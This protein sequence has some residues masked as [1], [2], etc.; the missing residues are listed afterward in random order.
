MRRAV[1][2]GGPVVLCEHGAGQSYQ[3]NHSSY[4]GGRGREQV[5]LFLC[6]NE[7]AAERNR[8]AYPGVPA[9]A[10]GCPKLD[11]YHLSP[12][13]PRGA[14]PVLALSFHWDC[15]VAPESRWA[16]PPYRNVLPGL[17]SAYHVLGHGHPR[18][19]PRLEEQY[20][21]MRLEPVADFDEVMRRADLYICDNSSTLFEFASTG[22]P[23]VVLNAPYYRREVNHGLRFWEA[24]TVGIQCDDP[25]L[26]L[27]AVKQAL[28]DLPEQQAARQA[29]VSLAYAH[30]DG[31]A[32]ERGAEAI[33]GLLKD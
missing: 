14:P 25:H 19:W 32:A 7:A 11:A 4:A 13:K 8:H 20:R 17:A 26:L 3:G 30:T 22:R 9:L 23:V 29:A 27:Q 18:V 31:R 24:A 12:A 16:F 5:V 2:W 33:L 6:P 10:I 1:A 21:N 15:L 28:A